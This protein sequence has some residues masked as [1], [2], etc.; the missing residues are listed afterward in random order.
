ML[1]FPAGDGGENSFAIQHAGYVGEIDQTIRAEIFG[2]GRSHVIR[3]DVVELVVGAEAEARGH[4][5]ESLAP[6]GFEK[7]GVDPGEIPD[8][9]EAA[10]YVVVDQRL[11][12]K[13]LGIRRGNADGWVAFSGNSGRQTFV[14]QA[15][16]DH[17]GDV[18]S[19]AVGHTEAGN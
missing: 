12:V 4:G 18:A 2:A 5:D 9:A 3:V 19:L 17:H 6:K 16:E 10:L 1:N 13:T 11:R 8:E 7:L 14:E 15:R